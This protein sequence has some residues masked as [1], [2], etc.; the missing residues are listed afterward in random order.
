MKIATSK[1]TQESKVSVR[2]NQ[3]ENPC[4]HCLALFKKDFDKLPFFLKHFKKVTLDFQSP[5]GSKEVLAWLP[6]LL[7]ARTKVLVCMLDGCLMDS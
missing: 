1:K 2:K 7:E 6:H 3:S 4:S 5:V